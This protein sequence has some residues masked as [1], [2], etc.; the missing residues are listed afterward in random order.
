MRIRMS[1]AVDAYKVVSGMGQ[2]SMQVQTALKLFR[3]KKALEPQF[4]FY[5][6]QE[7]RLIKTNGGTI[8][9]TG[10]VKF[11]DAEKQLTFLQERREM[12]EMEVD[13]ETEPVK[14]NC[15]D[16]KEITVNELEALDGLIDFE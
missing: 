13:L 16:L 3:L 14:I 6:E 10:N 9:E 5:R 2:K 8:S 12:N 11:T 7:T 1:K 4:E 15:A